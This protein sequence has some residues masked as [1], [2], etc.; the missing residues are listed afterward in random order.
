MTKVTQE[1]KVSID[2]KLQEQNKH[3]TGIAKQI[4]EALQRT[5]NT[6]AEIAKIETQLKEKPDEKREV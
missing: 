3:I 2:F 5:K 6:Q 1:K 4:R